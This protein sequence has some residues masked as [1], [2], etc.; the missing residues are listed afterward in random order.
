LQL[1]REIQGWYLHPYDPPS[2]VGDDDVALRYHQAG[3]L[4]ALLVYARSDGG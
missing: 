3:W 2:G 4:R 1:Q